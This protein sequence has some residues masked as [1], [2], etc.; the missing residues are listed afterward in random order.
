L[1]FFVVSR[2][3]YPLLDEFWVEGEWM[4]G[5]KCLW[6]SRYTLY[7]NMRTMKHGVG[8]RHALDMHVEQGSEGGKAL[9]DSNTRKQECVLEVELVNGVFQTIYTNPSEEVMLSSLEISRAKTS[10]RST[11]CPQHLPHFPEHR[12]VLAQERFLDS[13]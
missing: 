1:C 13:S 2:Y 5:V 4:T 9:L 6:R 7:T 11:Q 10:I 3:Q 8:G 12:S